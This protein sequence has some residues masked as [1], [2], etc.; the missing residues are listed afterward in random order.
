MLQKFRKVQRVFVYVLILNLTVAFVK[1][2]YGN[3][4]GTLSMSADGY[5]SLFD[6]TSNI[7]GLAGSFVASHPPDKGH[8][9]GHKKY[10]TVA[11]FL[12]LYC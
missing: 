8:P 3:L 12:S 7:V 10:E 6:G 2:I 9:Y 5:H 1:I 4:T 11:S